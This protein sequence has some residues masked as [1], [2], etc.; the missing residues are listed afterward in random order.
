LTT[1]LSSNGLDGRRRRL[2][3]RSWHRGIKEMDLVMGR[4]ADAHLRAFSDD[5][6]E[7]FEVLLTIPDQQM[8]AW[9]LGAEPPDPQFDTPMFRR[10]RTF[11]MSD[12]VS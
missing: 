10:L 12:T 5:D 9:V 3:F 11:H 8:L 6:L 1:E 2:L 7:A 4:F